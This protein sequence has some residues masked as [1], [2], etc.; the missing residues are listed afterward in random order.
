MADRDPAGC[1]LEVG[2]GRAR[3]RGQ[4]AVGGD[5]IGGHRA[6]AGSVVGVRDEE[7]VRIGRP[8]LASERADLLRREWRPGCRGQPAVT[9]DREAVDKGGAGVGA[10]ARADEMAAVA[11]EQD[12]TG[13]RVVGEG[14]GRVGERVQ[15]AAGTEPEPA[16]V[17]AAGPGIGDV[18]EIAMDRDADWGSAIG[19]LEIGET[20]RPVGPDPEHRDLVRRDVDCEQIAAIAG[21]LERARRAGRR[22]GASRARVE[23]CPSDR[24]ERAIGVPVKARD[25]VATGGVVV[26]VEVS[27]DSGPGRRKRHACGR[28]QGRDRQD[29]H[30]CAAKESVHAVLPS[31]VVERRAASGGSMTP[32]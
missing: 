19:W 7:L 18:H 12:L 16:V 5:V 8:E 24:R 15:M 11:T 1:G 23:R 20:K 25:R 30:A 14:V 22:T 26:H 28:Q 32:S 27:Y 17:A 6:V 31:W 9:A 29:D 13:Q 4:G 3:D 2:E 21:E 10:D